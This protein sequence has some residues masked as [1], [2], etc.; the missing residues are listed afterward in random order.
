MVDEVDQ[1]VRHITWTINVQDIRAM[2][3]NYDKRKNWLRAVW[4]ERG[5]ASTYRTEEW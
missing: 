1:V 4:V 2:E 3:L 5:I